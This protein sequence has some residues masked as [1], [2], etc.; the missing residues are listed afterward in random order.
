MPERMT[1]DDLLR[2]TSPVI[3]GTWAAQAMGMDSGRFFEYA[4]AGKLPF[5]AITSG[6]RVKVSRVAFLRFWG[7]TDEQIERGWEKNENIPANP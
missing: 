7:Y 5:N 4:R 2:V 1:C 6:N 3:P